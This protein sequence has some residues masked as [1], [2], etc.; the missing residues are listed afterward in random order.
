MKSALEQVVAAAVKDVYGL[1]VTVELTRPEPQFGDYATNVALQLAKQLGQNPRTIA[2]TLANHVKGQSS[3]IVAA[4]VAGPGFL[5][6]RLSDQTLLD[7][8]HETPEKPLAGQTIVTEYSDPNP[9]KVLHIGHFYTGVVGDAISNVLQNAGAHVHRVNFGGDVGLHVGKTMWAI[10]RELGG[11][12]PEKLAD[13]P[14]DE[15]SEWMARC[16]V[17]G[18]QAYEDDETARR[19]II[20]ANKRVYSLHSENDH[21]SAFASIYWTCRTW[22]Y[23]YFDAFY[24]RIGSSF[25]RYYPESQTAEL[26]LA[27]VKEQLAKGV[28]EESDGAV[29]FDGEKYGL[30]TRV[31]INS[32]G[33]PTYETKDVGLSRKK[34]EDYRFDTSVIITG[35][36]IVEYM[37]VVLKAIEQFAPN[38]AQRTRH[39]THGNVKLA[40]GVKM[41]SRK[42][43]FVRAVDVLD[44]AR[45]ANQAIAGRNNESTVLAA[46]KYSFLKNRIGA[47]I[48]FEP[49]ESVALEGNSGPYLQYAHARARSILSKAQAA[50]GALHASGE[51]SESGEGE[52]TSDEGAALSEPAQATAER[53]TTLEPGERLL[54]CKLTEYPEVIAKT[55]SELMP[56]YICTYLYE[57]AQEFNRFYEKN[58]VIGDGREAV[59]LRLVEAYAETLQNGLALLGIAAPERM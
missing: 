46:I 47:D 19:E 29:V 2:E 23:D 38:L 45:E 20:A 41:S 36:D 48:I 22:S 56:H 17:A 6:L 30:H 59:R 3:H 16:Y 12:K 4:E 24:E 51:R 7:G 40:G 44:L 11:E 58:R 27:T 33:L 34:W 52:P 49:K 32:E 18:T 28:F 54:V 21:D 1:A 31:F 55:T 14:V 35:N 25:E 53:Q 10:I 42:G 9:F 39:I 57:L 5:N 26:G 50:T 8:L 43:N 13:I 15:R 37:K